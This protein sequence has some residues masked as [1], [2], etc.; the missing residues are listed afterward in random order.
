MVKAYLRYE[1]R[2]CFGVVASTSSGAKIVEGS[3]SVLSGGNWSQEKT[4]LTPALEAVNLWHLRKG[5]LIKRLVPTDSSSTSATASLG[6]AG[7]GGEKPIGIVTSLCRIQNSHD[8]AVG[9]SSGTVK[10]WN[11]RGGECEKSFAGHKTAVSSLQYS[12]EKK[13]LA[14]GG[15]DSDIVLWD[16]V[17]ET[18]LFRLKGHKN[19]VTSLVFVPE[20]DSLISCSKD[21]CIRVWNLQL[22]HCTQV[23]TLHRGEIWSMDLS[24]DG[25]CLVTGSLDEQLLCF[26]VKSRDEMEAE[27]EGSKRSELLA[28]SGTL[29]RRNRSRIQ[30]VQ[31]DRMTPSTNMVPSPSPN[32]SPKSRYFDVLRTGKVFELYRVRTAK[33]TI[34][35]AKRRLKRKREEQGSGS[36]GRVGKQQQQRAWKARCWNQPKPV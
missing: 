34:K 25:K 19:E 27:E 12:K 20:H 8:V 14:S 5:V 9:Y 6:G 15:R 21:A 22:Q 32:A 24:L 31:L 18:G 16:L 26:R 10:V 33:E 29:V 30:Q 23:V 17:A 2:L 4:V 7:G 11:L 1:H 35:K 13:V 28:Q 36:W 3:G